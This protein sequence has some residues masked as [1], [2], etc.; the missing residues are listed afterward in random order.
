MWQP[1]GKYYKH[2]E[3][4]HV[5][6]WRLYPGKKIIGIQSN[7]EYI[8]MFIAPII[9]VKS[10]TT[11]VWSRS[12]DTD[13]NV[14]FVSTNSFQRKLTITI[15]I[16]IN[17]WKASASCWKSVKSRS[18]KEQETGKSGKPWPPTSE[19]DT[20]PRVEENVMHFSTL[21]VHWDTINH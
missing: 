6:I 14:A 9:W 13:R 3:C 7:M 12:V 10:P 8:V 21:L 18:S 11:N 5:Q 4:G 1:Q 2:F 16:Q 19:L 20:A 17:S 15:Y